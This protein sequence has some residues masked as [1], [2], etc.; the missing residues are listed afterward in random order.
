MVA[1][2]IRGDR[3]GRLTAL[4]RVADIRGKT[5][6]E[7]VCDCGARRVVPTR[8]LRHGDAAA[9]KRCALA[10]RAVKLSTHGLSRPHKVTFNIWVGM[11]GRCLNP[12]HHA[13]HNYGGRGIKVCDRWRDDFPAFLSDM[14]PRPSKHHTIDRIDNDGDYT[15]DNCRWATASEQS[16]NRRD[17]YR[18]RHDG[19]VLSLAE[20]CRVTG[21]NAQ[22]VYQRV[23]RRR[24]GREFDSAA[25]FA[26]VASFRSAPQ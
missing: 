1:L 8:H 18:V 13:F 4:R 10:A 7:C 20:F 9:C 24:L 25:I 17:C 3:Y 21:L 5:A 6:W 2:D 14:G 22:A 12:R 16:C 15:P 11:K 19:G 23:S 26:P